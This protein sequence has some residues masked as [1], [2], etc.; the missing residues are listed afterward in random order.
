[1]DRRGGMVWGEGKFLIELRRAETGFREGVAEL[2][3]G[4]ESPAVGEGA[5]EFVDDLAV[6]FDA[7]AHDVLNDGGGGVGFLVSPGI[8]DD[9]AAG[10]GVAAA[11]ATEFEG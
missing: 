4:P 10:A 3:D 9:F 7:E 2:G 11:Q 1:M 6:D 5:G 8:V